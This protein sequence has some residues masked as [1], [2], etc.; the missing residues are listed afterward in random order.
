MSD[1]APSGATCAYDPSEASW[2]CERCGNFFCEPCAR[3]TRP[4]A[5][6]LCKS[7]WDARSKFVDLR[8]S[9][10]RTNLQT[11]GLVLGVLSLIPFPV[12]QL[13]SIIVNVLGISRAREG[14]PRAHRWKN[15][16]GLV[17]SLGVLA[18][19]LLLLL[20]AR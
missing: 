7:C 13:A 18:L 9:E 14:T 16:V 20:P 15:I 4:E 6:P 3:R 1:R 8:K 2:T 11:A 10:S 5:F 19:E 17:I 12:F